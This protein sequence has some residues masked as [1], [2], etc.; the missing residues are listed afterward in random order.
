[1]SNDGTYQSR[2]LMTI[3]KAHGDAFH[4]PPIGSPKGIPLETLDGNGNAKLWLFSK[5]LTLIILVIWCILY[6]SNNILG[7]HT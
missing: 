4:F 2:G 5:I 3:L 6:T 1:M 7:T